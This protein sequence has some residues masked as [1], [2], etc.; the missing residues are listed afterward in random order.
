MVWENGSKIVEVTLHSII[1]LHFPQVF[2]LL[3]QLFRRWKGLY[4][5][6]RV[7]QVMTTIQALVIILPETSRTNLGAALASVVLY[8]Q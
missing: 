1:V 4:L 6:S 3:W 5:N 8:D 7:D 2:K